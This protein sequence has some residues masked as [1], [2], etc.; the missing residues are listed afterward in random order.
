MDNQ[1]INV[2]N[3]VKDNKIKVKVKVITLETYQEHARKNQ[4]NVSTNMLY[5]CWR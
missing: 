2:K 1:I 5:G 3:N 4:P